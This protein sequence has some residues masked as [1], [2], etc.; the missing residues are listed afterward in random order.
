MA[1]GTGLNRLRNV[2]KIPNQ[3]K[4]SVN[5]AYEDYQRSPAAG[6]P[7]NGKIFSKISRFRVYKMNIRMVGFAPQH[8]G[9][10]LIFP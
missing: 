9:R 8:A 6:E 4:K 7:D 2:F 3:C 10:A 5:E 1:P